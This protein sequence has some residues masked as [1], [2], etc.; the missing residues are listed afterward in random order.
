MSSA[1]AYGTVKV[2]ME[3]N[4]ALSS[5]KRGQLIKSADGETVAYCYTNGMINV[6]PPW[7]RVSREIPL[8]MIM[9][10]SGSI[11][12]IPAGWALCNGQNGTPDLRDKFVLGAGGD[13][14]PGE[15][16]A[17]STGKI[18]TDTEGIVSSAIGGGSGH[19][20]FVTAVYAEA[21]SVPYYALAFIMK[22]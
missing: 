1:S 3:G 11:V 19:R 18:R 2:C 4:M 9:L 8:G 6:V 13:K 15:N 10:W 12:D 7:N 20:Q 14:A 22:L 21:D 17:G 5:A 16:S